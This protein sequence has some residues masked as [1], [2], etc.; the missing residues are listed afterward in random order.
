VNYQKELPGSAGYAE[1]QGLYAEAGLSLAADLAALQA[2]PRIA[3]DPAAVGYLTRNIAFDG[4]LGGRPVLTL[5]TTGG[6][7]VVNQNE[8][9][10]RSAVKNAKDAQLLRQAFVHRAGYCSFTPAETIAAFQT[11]IDR[12]D[13]GTWTSSTDPGALNDRAAALG[14][15]LNVLRV[16][17]N[18]VPQAAA[19]LASSRRRSRGCSILL[20][21]DLPDPLPRMMITIAW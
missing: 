16:G 13:H 11:L 4:Q 15:D 1:V 9:A 21:H 14:P 8:Q 17:T 3:A 7:W 20:R 2:A 10:Y 12:I 19:F 6:G 18:V 5:H